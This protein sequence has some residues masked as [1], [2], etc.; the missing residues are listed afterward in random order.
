MAK[1]NRSDNLGYPSSYTSAKSTT[2]PDGRATY[3]EKMYQEGYAQAK[4]E[5]APED[6]PVPVTK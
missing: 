1:N 6:T 4:G 5:A 2:P 3:M